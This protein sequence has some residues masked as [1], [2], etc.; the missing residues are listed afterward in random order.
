[1]E[2]EKASEM[3]K[4][5][6]WQKWKVKVNGSFSTPQVENNFSNQS[7]LGPTVSDQHYTQFNQNPS[8]CHDI[9]KK[10]MIHV[11]IEGLS[12]RFSSL[13]NIVS[14]SQEGR[15]RGGGG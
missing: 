4:S 10:P 3:I 9:P 11:K 15:L 6:K 14:R 7:N 12:Q 1:M 8:F 13:I 5:R 2:D